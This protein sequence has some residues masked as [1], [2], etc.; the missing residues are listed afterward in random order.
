MIKRFQ[1]YV[2]NEPW[3]ESFRKADRV[4]TIFCYIV[5]GL[6]V[7]YFGGGYLY[8]FLIGRFGG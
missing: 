5:M 7:A 1:D 4:L 6:A 3:E 8:A 2:E